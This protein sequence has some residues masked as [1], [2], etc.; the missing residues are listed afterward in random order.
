MYKSM[1]RDHQIGGAVN[2][3]D[4]GVPLKDICRNLGISTAPFHQWPTTNLGMKVSDITALA[5]VQ[6]PVRASTGIL[7][8]SYSSFGIKMGKRSAIASTQRS[9][10]RPR[11]RPRG[12]ARG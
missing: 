7:T 2:R 6:C 9:K 11:S 3:A 1:L 8:S 10:S 4:D 12:R 5:L